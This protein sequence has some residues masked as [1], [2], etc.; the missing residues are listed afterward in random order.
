MLNPFRKYQKRS[1]E[2]VKLQNVRYRSHEKF[3]YHIPLEKGFNRRTV[4]PAEQMRGLREM[5][6]KIKW[7]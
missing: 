2:E 6:A 3:T 1:D 7:Q 5:A 4:L